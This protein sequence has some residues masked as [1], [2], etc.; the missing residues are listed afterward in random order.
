LSYPLPIMC[1]MPRGMRGGE[2]KAEVV[3]SLIARD[4][5]RCSY[6]HGG[7]APGKRYRTVDHALPLSLGGTNALENLRLA[8][9]RCNAQKGAATEHAYRASRELAERRRIVEGEHLR[10]LGVVLPKRAYHHVKL[11]W[12]GERRWA[13]RACHLSNLAGTRSP[14]TVPCR[15]LTTWPNLC[16]GMAELPAPRPNQIEEHDVIGGRESAARS[17]AVARRIP[18]TLGGLSHARGRRSGGGIALL[19]GSVSS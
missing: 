15:L 3:A 13:C 17:R 11:R 16:P 12:F 18:A 9:G 2:R 6:C 14:A 5:N 4:G 10:I 8:C 19:S 1:G 7:F